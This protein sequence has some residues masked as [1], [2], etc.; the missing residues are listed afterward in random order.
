V[1]V[2]GVRGR[3]QDLVAGGVRG[4]KLVTRDAQPGLKH[5]SAAVG[6]GAGWLAATLRSSLAPPDRAAAAAHRRHGGA[7]LAQRVPTLV[8]R[9]ADAAG[10][11]LTRPA[12]RRRCGALVAEPPAAGRGGRRACSQT[13]LRKV[14]RPATTPCRRPTPR[15]HPVAGL[16]SRG[17]NFHL[18]TGLHR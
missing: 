1:L 13:A 2:D 16:H 11:L 8:H 7:T 12:G 5:A 3:L 17:P 9:L 10:Q 18:L 6:V 14:L 4:L 15:H